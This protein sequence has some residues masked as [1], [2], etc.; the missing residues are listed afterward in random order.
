[1]MD[2]NSKYWNPYLGGIALGIVLFLSYFILGNGLGA[3]GALQRFMAW[4][5]DLVGPSYTAESPFWGK[6]F[7]DGK[8]VWNHWLIYEVF[9]ILIGG[10][11]SGAIAGRVK[12]ETVKG[13]RVKSDKRRWI[14]AFIG[15]IFMGYGARLARGCASG[16]ALSGGAVMSAGSWAFM[17][18][19]FAVAYA[20]AYFFRKEWT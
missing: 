7:A 1:M 17:F 6:Y 14:M 5:V 15:G 2:K 8:S 19:I 3:S 11:V 10:F 12:F 13:P 20:L 4:L 18:T 16:Q 9:G